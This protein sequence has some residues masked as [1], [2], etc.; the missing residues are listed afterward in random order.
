M[1]I[2]IIDIPDQPPEGHSLPGA[3]GIGEGGLV[4]G[5]GEAL[6][7]GVLGDILGDRTVQMKGPALGRGGEDLDLCDVA[8]A[9]TG[10]RGIVPDAAVPVLVLL[11]K[12]C[13]HILVAED[14]QP[15]GVHRGVCQEE[16]AHPVTVRVLLTGI[17]PGQHRRPLPGLRVIDIIVREFDL[18]AVRRGQLDLVPGR[19]SADQVAEVHDVGP[20]D[21]LVYLVEVLIL[22]RIPLV[23]PVEDRTLH[24]VRGIPVTHHRQVLLHPGGR[25]RLLVDYCLSIPLVLDDLKLGGLCRDRHGK[26]QQKY[27]EDH[28][29]SIR[30]EHSRSPM[31]PD[32]DHYQYKLEW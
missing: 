22:G 10:C 21:R 11:L 29:R 14:V 4:A 20:L 31:L 17:P 23:A 9:E 26:N 32:H 12:A 7:K 19:H 30:S 8:V 25:H 18:I 13:P 1:G 2:G 3:G 27:A 28:R 24:D 15:L 16:E 6:L 5:P